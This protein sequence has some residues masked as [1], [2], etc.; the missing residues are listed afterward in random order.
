LNRRDFLRG[1]LTLAGLG[2]CGCPRTPS[3]PALQGSRRDPSFE[4][5]HRLRRPDFP[6]QPDSVERC[7]GVILGGGVAGLAA[8]WRWSRAG[9]ED[10]RLLELEPEAGGN[11]RALSYP[12]TSAPIG[13]HYLPIPN[14]EARA[15]RRLL[16]EM[17]VLTER[18]LEERH[19]CHSRQERIFYQGSWH[20]GLVPEKVLPESALEQFQRFTTEIQNWATRRDRRGRKV[21]AL[22][23]Q[24]SSTE[25][26][27][28]E[29][30]RLSFGEYA[31]RRGWNDPYL[32]W[33]LNYA[34]RDDFGGSIH[35]CSAW[36]GLHYFASRDGGGLGSP[37][38]ILVW[39][40]G[41]HR[42]VKFLAEQQQGS[43]LTEALILEVANT[44]K[45]V[46]VDYLDLSRGRR[47]R[48]ECKVAIFC[49]P[50]FLRPYLTETSRSVKS[51]VYAPWV[52]ANLWLEH[53][54]RDREAPG[55]IAWDNVIHGSDSLGYVVATHQSLA[56][57]PNRSTVWTW[58]RPFP[59]ED[60]GEARTR[61]QNSSWTHWAEQVL[62]ELELYHSDIRSLC[63]QLDVT[64]LGHGMI[65]PS[66]GFIWG[67]ELATARQKEGRIFYGHGDL[68]GM[69]LFEESQYQ[70]VVAAEAALAELGLAYSSYL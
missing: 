22:P 11:S 51:F 68:S 18:G 12:P 55:H 60:P 40:E 47:K 20:E 41:N 36:A 53:P 1:S 5:G 56:T 62:G 33:Y 69:S 30:D 38:D 27:F 50:S 57:D 61:L 70:G 16:R 66:V 24:L 48:L 19:L 44:E 10:Y 3:R 31:A 17:G 32:L 28:L 25:P 46:R 8:G 45:G 39:P 34:C 37:D 13:A 29:L 23:L 63:K 15:V 35:N 21:F 9:F 42:L 58:Y 6:D 7:D 54:P 59:D 67:S 52:T 14:Q 64:V 4:A 49:L 43:V 26:E 2:L 65:R